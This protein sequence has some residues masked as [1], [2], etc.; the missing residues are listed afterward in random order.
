MK[1]H[2]NT[3]MH[4][5]RKAKRI[6]IINKQLDFLKFYI[7]FPCPTHLSVQSLSLM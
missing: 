2:F 6:Y 3:D 5:V 7:E 1:H 4:N